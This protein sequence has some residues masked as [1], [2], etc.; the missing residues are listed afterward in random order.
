MFGRL[1]QVLAC[2]L[3][4]RFYGIEPGPRPYYEMLGHN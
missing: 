1:Y 4:L 2:T 3:Y